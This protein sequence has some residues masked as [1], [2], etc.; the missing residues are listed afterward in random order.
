MSEILFPKKE[1]IKLPFKPFRHGKGGCVMAG[2][3]LQKPPKPWPTFPLGPACVGKW[4][5]KINGKIYYFGNWARRVNGV[6]TPIPDGGWQNALDEYNAFLSQI[7]FALVSIIAPI[8]KDVLKLVRSWKSWM[9][10]EGTPGDSGPL[11]YAIINSDGDITYIGS[12]S[13]GLWT[14]FCS[15]SHVHYRRATRRT[16]RI[17]YSP[18]PLDR[19]TLMESFLICVL[20]P[21]L[22]K[23]YRGLGISSTF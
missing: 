10:A 19:I 3:G 21:P 14:R 18:V 17:F 5:K 15:G 2:T 23:T 9:P 1:E 6:L 11:V 7:P 8:K 20:D 4:Q 16:H 22:N 13:K 12:T